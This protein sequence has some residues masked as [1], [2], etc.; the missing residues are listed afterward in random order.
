M[1]GLTADRPDTILGLKFYE[2]E[3]SPNTFSSG[4]Y[5]FCV[6]DFSFF[7]IVTALDMTV[8]VLKELYSEANQTGLIGRLEVDAMPVLGEAFARSKLA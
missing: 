8:S 6:G 4:E 3:Y 2:S 7:W 1:P 5:M